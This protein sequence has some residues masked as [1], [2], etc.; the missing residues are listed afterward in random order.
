ME[1]SI[2]AIRNGTQIAVTSNQRLDKCYDVV[3]DSC[4]P[5]VRIHVKSGEFYKG[6]IE[7]RSEPPPL[8]I[9]L[10]AD[11]IVMVTTLFSGID[12]NI[13]GFD[14]AGFQFEFSQADAVIDGMPESAATADA[15]ML[16]ALGAGDFPA[17]Q[18]W[19][20]E[21]AALM[22]NA[23][24]DR[25]SLAYSSLTYVTGFTAM[26]VDPVGGEGGPLVTAIGA[27]DAAFPV[28]TYEGRDVLE[29]Y[30]A[31]RQIPAKPGS[32]DYATS[33]T[34]ATIDT[35]TAPDATS[36]PKWNSP[37]FGGF[38]TIRENTISLPGKV[39]AEDVMIDQTGRFILR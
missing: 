17:A 31:G 24:Y 25:L 1:V 32:W 13:P 20:N 34:I 3:L 30:Q 26:G 29:L 12:K 9:A 7:C 39:T 11:R 33:S 5:E 14:A 15:A 22:H 10:L 23:G 6:S 35:V 36:T 8:E 27:P 4:D 38:D 19:A 21:M 28:M 16:A 2:T 37:D 18:R